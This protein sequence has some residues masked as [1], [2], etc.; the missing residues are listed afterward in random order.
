MNRHYVLLLIILFTFCYTYAQQ[1]ISPYDHF[2]GKPLDGRDSTYLMNLPELT[3]PSSLRN[4]P[5]PDIVD[6]SELP[7]LR[8]VFR[9]E[10]AS[11]GQACLVGYNFTYEINRERN[12]AADVPENQY[13]THFTYN[14]MNGGNGWY[15]VSYMHSMEV[16]RL[17][18]NMNVIDYGGTFYD[19]GRRWIT[20]YDVYYNAMFNRIKGAYSINT[21]TLDGLMTLKHWLYNHMEEGSPGG[22]ASFYANTPWNAKALN[23]TTPEGGKTVLTAWA[24][25]AT[26][27]MTIIGYNDS[28]RWD[29]NEDG[30]YTNDI[31]INND[32]KI[33]AK[34][35]EIGGVKVVNSHGINAQDSGFFYMMYKV[36]AESFENGGIWNQSVHVLDIW[37]DYEPLLT[38]KIKL[39]HNY[40]ERI[41][42]R[43][44]VAAD[45]TAGQPEHTMA[46]PIFDFQGA[47]HYM[48]GQ[49]T[50]EYLKTIEFGL[51]ITPLLSYIK[52]GEPARFFLII[53]EDDPNNEGTGE[54]IEFSLMDYTGSLIET[55]CTDA[56]KL[57]V[58]NATTFASVIHSTQYDL[59][60]I[61]TESLP[62]FTS[63]NPYSQQLTV[64]GGNGPHSW[65]MVETYVCSAEPGSYN[66]INEHQVNFDTNEMDIVSIPLDF[67]FPFYGGN[68][69]TVFL[70]ADGFL[71]FNMEQ[72]PWPYL[73]D[74]LLHLKQN[75]II[76]PLTTRDFIME[77][78]KD[79]GAWYEADED[80]ATFRWQLSYMEVSLSTNY[81]FS[82]TLYPS[83]EIEFSYGTATIY[84]FDWVSGI[85]DGSKKNYSAS[86]IH[87]LEDFNQHPKVYFRPLPFPAGMSITEEGVFQGTPTSGNKVWNLTFRVTDNK[88]ISAQKNLLFSNGPQINYH[89]HAGDNGSIDYGETVIMDATVL[90]NGN[91][92]LENIQLY[93]QLEDPY[94]DLIDGIA[95]GG[96]INASDSVT[97]E[98]CF[99]FTVDHETPDQHLLWLT[100]VL[101]SGGNSWNLD[102]LEKVNAPLFKLMAWSVEDGNNQLLEP[103]EIADIRITLINE[104]RAD[105]TGVTGKVTILDPVV[106]LTST[107]PINFGDLIHGHS[108]SN[109]FS[110]H[111]MEGIISGYIVPVKLEVSCDQQITSTDT[112]DMTVG[113]IPVLVMD[114]DPNNHT[115]PVIFQ[116]FQDMGV[117]SEYRSYIPG[118]LSAYQS[119]FVCLG[120]YHSNYELNWY[121]GNLLASYLDAGGRMYLEGRKIWRDDL[122]TPVHD[123]FNIIPE[124]TPLWLKDIAGADSTFAEG[125]FMFNSATQPFNFY[126]IEPVP[127]AFSLMHDTTNLG[128]CAVAFDQGTYRTVG[129]IF[130]M[131]SLEDGEHPSTKRELLLRILNF[132]EVDYSLTAVQ[133]MSPVIDDIPVSVFPNPFRTNITFEFNVL[134]QE[135]DVVLEIYDIQG[136]SVR[137][138]I[139]YKQFPK[140]LNS[141]TWNRNNNAGQR[142]KPGV[143]FYRF[144]SG[145]KAS[146]GKIIILE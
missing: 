61:T 32:G 44:G 82:V 6:N 35:W 66:P 84:P 87:H 141:W 108:C 25:E 2:S 23:D 51:D 116:L 125:I 48:Q 34:D 143:Y 67:D 102:V 59:P 29:Y 96:T 50:A 49:D 132:F 94:V 3:I 145:N 27:A 129:T 68:Y 14:F 46:Y 91:S 52:P 76:A 105:M 72:L 120:F 19:D 124:G 79:D 106:E 83:G 75:R 142:V 15:G 71:Q 88:N 90:N 100:T 80:Q 26:H 20:G 40:R 65:D 138:L 58:E 9:Q 130:E 7:Y 115:G 86:P 119:L 99:S 107:N 110:V 113:K 131:G 77:M 122:Y 98:S 13:A 56:P 128:S 137:N 117:L 38:Y 12:L 36:L 109:T 73:E 127:P 57:L 121:E 103:G 47:N 92:P 112:I 28:I 42:V 146:S 134:G 69:D 101:N 118:N 135:T 62:A 95:S 140:G 41:A 89:L 74:H 24:P 22:V 30:A 54:L 5:L 64:S 39:K 10:A 53:E 8:P 16:L 123:R 17:C 81:D 45:I 1:D 55:P 85:S 37:E 111:A 126:Q 70:N 136:R 97:I 33:D 78:E 93:L 18:G 144:Y 104:G 133:E 60:I 4:N 114:L 139:N 11:C 31:D 63:G 21:S 43:A